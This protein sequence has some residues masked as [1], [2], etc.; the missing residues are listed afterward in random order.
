[1]ANEG[2]DIGQRFFRWMCRHLVALTAFYESYNAD[3]S[4]HHRDLLAYSGFV[5]LLHDEAYWVTAGHCLN[6]F[7]EILGKPNVK[8][9]DIAFAD[10]F[11]L[12]AAY[13]HHIP[14][15][16]EPGRWLR[17]HRPDLQLDFAIIPLPYLVTQAFIKNNVK[18]VDR[19]NWVHQD[20]LDFKFYRMLGI[21]KDFVGIDESGNGYMRPAS[22]VVE[23][24]S[25]EDV[26]NPPPDGWFIG[27]I[28]PEATIKDIKGMSGGPIFG[29]RESTAGQWAY[30]FVAVQSWWRDRSRIV[31]GCS[32]PFFAEFLHQ[33]IQ[34][35]NEEEL[36]RSDSG[37]EA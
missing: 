28:H 12:E 25:R 36:N 14:F 22:F 19:R 2:D 37:P 29:F 24:L 7:D 8:V 27:R 13:T 6:D 15:P 31:F 11:G 20:S 10:Y 9:Y 18:A 33:L 26:E 1:M 4:I 34:E 23:Q 30:H 35:L 17:V 5:M 16:Y 21:P 3:G 32:V